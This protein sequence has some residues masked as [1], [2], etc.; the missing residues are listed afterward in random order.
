MNTLH[1]GGD[2]CWFIVDHK[3]DWFF[4]HFLVLVT[5]RV[6]LYDSHSGSRCEPALVR[7]THAPPK[8]EEVWQ[9]RYHPFMRF[10]LCSSMNWTYIVSLGSILVRRSIRS[11]IKWLV[12]LLKFKNIRTRWKRKIYGIWIGFWICTYLRLVPYLVVCIWTWDTP[13]TPRASLWN[14]PCDEVLGAAQCKRL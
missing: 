4:S 7:L 13:L 10:S 8:G 9:V 2:L 5:T 6:R 3:G 11:K 14:K 12:F 1:G